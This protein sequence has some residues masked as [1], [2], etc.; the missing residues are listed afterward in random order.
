MS[1]VEIK[2]PKQWKHWC[3][4]ANLRANGSYKKSHANRDKSGFFYLKGRGY[5]WRVNCFGDLQRGDNYADFDRWAL[6][7]I[8]EVPMPN[9]EAKFMAAVKELRSKGG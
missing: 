8:D 3:R 4:K 9:T 7:N 1:K 2:L 5:H 6:C